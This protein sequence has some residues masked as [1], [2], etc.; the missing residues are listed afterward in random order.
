MSA[1][2]VVMPG[3]DDRRSMTKALP[4]TVRVVSSPSERPDVYRI[5]VAHLQSLKEVGAVELI[6]RIRAHWKTMPVVFVSE[7]KR[8]A[9]D[10]ALFQHFAIASRP[11]E[12]ALVASD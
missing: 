3:T 6:S 11:T 1:V 2:E 8:T 4:S 9:E 5:V 7:R 10:T 12:P